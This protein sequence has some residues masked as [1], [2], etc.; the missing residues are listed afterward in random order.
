MARVAGNSQKN[1][2]FGHHLWMN[3]CKCLFVCL[4][5]WT[6]RWSRWITL[7][8]L[9][10]SVYPIFQGFSLTSINTFTAH[11]LDGVEGKRRRKTRKNLEKPP[12]KKSFLTLG[13]N[14]P[15]VC[16]KLCKSKTLR[17][18]ELE[19]CILYSA[20]L[21]RRAKLHWVFVQSVES[22]YLRGLNT[23]SFAL[24]I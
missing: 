21:T 4:F 20:V 13:H 17:W 23:F 10:K 12:L 19:V 11:T 16:Y 7:Q 22:I 14:F 15:W 3:L 2:L 24:L 18:N 8:P 5:R 1:H 6:A 9:T